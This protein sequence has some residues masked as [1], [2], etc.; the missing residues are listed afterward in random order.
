MRLAG[1]GTALEGRVCASPGFLTWVEGPFLGIVGQFLG[2]EG[3]F[4]GIVGR[5]LGI[6][7]PF[8]RIVGQFL[9]IVGSF[10]GI[11]GL[12]AP[13]EAP[14]RGIGGPPQPRGGA[15]K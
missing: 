15:R 2:V 11:E 12:P 8:L 6:A 14:D 7:G 10:P 9:R 13:A 5:F 4:S 3:R 1:G